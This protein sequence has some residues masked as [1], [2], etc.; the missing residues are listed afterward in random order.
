MWQTLKYWE[1]L[2]I[3]QA[4][5]IIK[6]FENQ[7]RARIGSKD[8]FHLLHKAKPSRLGGKTISSNAERESSKMN[9]GL[10]SKQNKIKLLNNLSEMEISN[11]SYKEFKVMVIKMHSKLGRGMD[12]HSKN[13][14]KKKI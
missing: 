10:H 13:F 7:P 4:A 8:K 12:E 11:L 1:L 5:W 2:T 6:K 3:K 14:N 9:R